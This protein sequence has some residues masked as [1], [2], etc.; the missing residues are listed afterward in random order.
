VAG[1]GGVGDEAKQVVG[2]IPSHAYVE[3]LA[4]GGA[5]GQE[6][7]GID[8]NAFGLVDCDGIREGDVLG[9]VGG[10]EDDPAEA[11]EVG[12]G[13]GA[14]VVAGLD[15]PSVTVSYPEPASADEAPVIAGGDDLVATAH[16]LSA[17]SHPVGFDLPSGNAFGS[18]PQG[19]RVH[20]GVVG[21]H[22]DDGLPGGPG[23]PPVGEGL[24]D[25]VLSGAA[26]D[27]DFRRHGPHVS[28]WPGPR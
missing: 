28:R 23:G 19:E 22:H 14:V 20:G 8:G 26:G 10:G 5:V 7:S 1:A 15:L 24:V 11:V 12:D 6:H 21:G 4:G 16:H 18:G 9:C 27:A 2:P 3:M 25:H 13:Q 17:D